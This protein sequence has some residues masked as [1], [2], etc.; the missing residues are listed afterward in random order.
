MTKWHIGAAILAFAI[1]PVEGRAQSALTVDFSWS[2]VQACT[3]KPPAFKISG[4]PAAAKRLR[5]VMKDLDKPSFDHGGGT[6]DYGGTGNI[7]AGAFFYTGPCPPGG[8]H[9]YQWTVQALD[10]S[11]RVIATGQATKPFPPR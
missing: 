10:A 2:G 1:A 8:S 3:T 11:G 7:P 4:I 5:F 6:V 9:Q